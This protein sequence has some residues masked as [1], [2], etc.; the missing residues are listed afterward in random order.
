MTVGGA[1]KIQ[2]AQPIPTHDV[3]TL[4]MHG[5]HSR[6]TSGGATDVAAVS[7]CK[8]ASLNG[9][10]QQSEYISLTVA[11]R[12]KAWRGGRARLQAP[13]R[14]SQPRVSQ[15]QK[16]EQAM[17]LRNHAM[18]WLAFL[19]LWTTACGPLSGF[20]MA[21]FFFVFEDGRRRGVLSW[22]GERRWAP[23]VLETL[24]VRMGLISARH[25]PAVFAMLPASRHGTL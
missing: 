19:T 14:G 25:S 15:L 6:K 5:P 17:D 11:I 13:S 7:A 2:S 9:L 8:R 20:A 23:G 21:L 18:G 1:R 12:D 4:I 22:Q 16:K 10:G 3:Y 24:G